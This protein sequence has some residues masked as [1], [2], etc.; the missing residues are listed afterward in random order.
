MVGQGFS[1]FLSTRVVFGLD[2]VQTS[3]G[4]TAAESS[5]FGAVQEKQQQGGGV[6][7]SNVTLEICY[8]LME[9]G[10]E[11]TSFCGNMRQF[12]MYPPNLTSNYWAFWQS[13]K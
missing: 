7:G 5:S 4:H 12:S 11:S 13:F 1:A 2:G 9:M 6:G 3:L 8:V 10:R